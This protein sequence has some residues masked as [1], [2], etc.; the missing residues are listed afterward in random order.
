MDS[1][2]VAAERAHGSPQVRVIAA[3]EVVGDSGL[4]AAPAAG[5]NE[6]QDRDHH[7][8]Q[9]DEH[10]LQHLVKDRGTQ[11][12]EGDVDRHCDRGD[13]DA[14]VDIPA[15]HHLHDQRHRVHVDAAHQDRHEPERDGRQATAGFPEAKLEVARHRVGLRDVVERHHH[16]AQ[17][18][19]GGDGADPIP[20]RGQD[21]VL[22]GRGRPSHQLQG[23]E[24]GGQEAQARHPGC[25]LAPR[26]EE[27]F[28]G[29]RP[30]L[31]VKPDAQDG[32]E[33]DHNDRGVHPTERDQS[34]SGAGCK[35]AEERCH[36]VLPLDLLSAVGTRSV[37]RKRLQSSSVFTVQ[38]DVKREARPEGPAGKVPPPGLPRTGQHP[39]SAAQPPRRA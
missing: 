9:P 37:G 7:S 5:L 10:E 24:V 18:E 31:E 20:V 39:P 2:G 36:R 26:E 13:P 34:R 22:I 27:I 17:E 21:A 15:E 3:G 23:A 25:H 14:E 32:H 29:R 19:H 35:E 16:H 11:A 8:P 12:A 30:C 28:A 6:T 38:P 1:H 4:E 33:V